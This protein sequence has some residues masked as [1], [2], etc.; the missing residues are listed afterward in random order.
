[1]SKLAHRNDAINM[2]M[3]TGSTAANQSHINDESKFELNPDSILMEVDEF[4]DQ[5]ENEKDYEP[6]LIEDQFVIKHPD[7]NDD[8]KACHNLKINEKSKPDGK[9]VLD[10]IEPQSVNFDCEFDDKMPNVHIP[11]YVYE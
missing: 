1:M 7:I 5:K 11:S 4:E 9:N 3:I 2:S 8:L 6:K 10:L